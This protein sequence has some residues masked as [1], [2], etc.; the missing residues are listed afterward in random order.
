MMPLRSISQSIKAEYIAPV[1]V[2]FQLSIDLVDQKYSG[3]EYLS[4]FLRWG[5]MY[6][7]YIFRTI[8]LIFVTLV[9]EMKG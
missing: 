1:V 2:S 4:I 3:Y 8:V 5:I 6:I 7:I 9:S